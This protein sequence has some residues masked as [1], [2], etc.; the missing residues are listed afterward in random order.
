MGGLA[1][2]QWLPELRATQILIVIVDSRGFLPPVVDPKGI[3]SWALVCI[4]ASTNYG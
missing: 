2:Q 4:R 3:L 1:R